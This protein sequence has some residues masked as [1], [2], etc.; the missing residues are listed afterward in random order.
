MSSATKNYQENGAIKVIERKVKCPN[1][2]EK[3]MITVKRRVSTFDGPL[4]T[5]FCLKC[6]ESF[7]L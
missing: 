4:T 5:Y 2:G 3:E 7:E 6:E 1:C